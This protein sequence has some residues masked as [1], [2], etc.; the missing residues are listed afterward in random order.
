M[1][2]AD[3]KIARLRSDYSSRSPGDDARVKQLEKRVQYLEK[4][5]QDLRKELEAFDVVSHGFSLILNFFS[6]AAFFGLAGFL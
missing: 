6:I 1:E 3:H 4:E 5:N 2:E